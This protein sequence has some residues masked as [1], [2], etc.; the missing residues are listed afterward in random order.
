VQRPRPLVLINAV[1][2]TRRILSLMPKCAARFRVEQVAPL[3]PVLPAV[4]MTA[5]ASLLTGRT[6]GDVVTADGVLPGHGIVANGW[7]FRDTMEVRFWQQSNQLLQAEPIYSRLKREYESAGRNFR[8]AKLF[9]W[10]NQ[11]AN[12]DLSVTPKPHYGSDGS[13]AFDIDV[14]PRSARPALDDLGAFPFSA[15]WGPMSGIQSS[16]WIGKLSERVIREGT[17]I[18][19]SN[20]PRESFD[21]TM[22]YLPHL[23]YDPQRDGPAGCDLRKCATE[24]DEIIAGIL[25]AADQTGADVWLVSE[26]GHV[27]V[28]RPVFLNR[29]LREQKLLVVRDGPF[30]ETLDTFNSRAFAVVD[31]Q[32]AHVYVRQPADVTTLVGGLQTIPGVKEVYAG[33]DRA[34]IGLNH[35]RSGELVLLSEPDA[36]FAYPYW[37]DDRRAPDF[38]GTVDIHRKP[39]FDPCEMF[40]DQNLFW[41]KGKAAFRLLQKTLGFR[42]RFDVISQDVKLVRGS[43]GLIPDHQDD[44]PILATETP[45]ETT[46]PRRL[47]DVYRLLLEK[48]RDR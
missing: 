8:V 37:L 47:T 30:G 4:T 35:A 2:L 40:F 26:Y 17:L 6:A 46:P 29:W 48:F 3:E 36:W 24:L 1:G 28:S 22:I 12:V 43:H 20:A 33:D 44:F 41:P 16:A 7:L 21:L 39:G 9:W 25:Q 45:L 11:G 23:D 38:A 31:H 34:K 5:Q 42:T 27:D 19:D 18:L 15:F 10:F 14:V 13:K 32:L